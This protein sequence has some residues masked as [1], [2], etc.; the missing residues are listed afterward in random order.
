MRC[1]LPSAGTPK[2]NS[3]HQ[4]LQL[5]SQWR[6]QA[7]LLV[8]KMHCKTFV[9]IRDNKASKEVSVGIIFVHREFLGHKELEYGSTPPPYYHGYNF[10]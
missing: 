2:T 10:L 7:L 5:L 1:D 9:E 3:T 4:E 8:L 6:S